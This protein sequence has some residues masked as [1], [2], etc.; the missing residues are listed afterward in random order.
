VPRRIGVLHDPSVR[1]TIANVKAAGRALNIELVFAPARTKP[2]IAAAIK[3]LIEAKVAAVNVLASTN[4]NAF[5]ADEIAAFA[6]ARLPAVY[7]WPETAEQGGLIG[8]GPRNLTVYRKL[9]NRVM[10]GLSTLAAER[11]DVEHFER[12]EAEIVAFAVPANTASL[13]VMEKLGMTRAEA[14][15]FDHPLVP[16]GHAL[17]RHVLYRLRRAP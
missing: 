15:D 4:L 9:V 8:Y 5:R 10:L 11:P 7:E 14:E 3:T 6:Q 2:E 12:C 17:R 16:V 13:R 1:E